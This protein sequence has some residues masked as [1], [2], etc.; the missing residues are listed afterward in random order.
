MA[1]VVIAAL[2]F[3]VFCLL[4][5]SPL[6]KVTGAAGVGFAYLS[7]HGYQLGRVKQKVQEILGNTPPP[8]P[9]PPPSPPDPPK[10]PPPPPVP[11]VSITI[12]EAEPPTGGFVRR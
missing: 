3:A 5:Q 6:E 8:P 9:A 10:P 2:V 12:N 4:G 11:P 7:A 1:I